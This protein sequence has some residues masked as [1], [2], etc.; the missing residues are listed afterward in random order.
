MNLF[1]F[2]GVAKAYGVTYRQIL[3]GAIPFL[4]IDAIVILIVAIFPEL[5]LWL[6]RKLH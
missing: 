6:P 4:I 5:A 2:E 1:V 3:K